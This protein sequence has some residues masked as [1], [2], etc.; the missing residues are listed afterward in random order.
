MLVQLIRVF[1]YR[2]FLNKGD[3]YLNQ[4]EE[5]G[6]L[7]SEKIGREKIYKNIRLIKLLAK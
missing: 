2:F 4:L 3:K 5:I 6:L 7:E 1:P